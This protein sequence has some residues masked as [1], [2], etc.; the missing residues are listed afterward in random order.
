MADSKE[1][2]LLKTQLLAIKIGTTLPPRHHLIDKGPP[3]SS[4]FVFL[5][6]GCKVEASPMLAKRVGM[7]PIPIRAEAWFSVVF[8]N[9]ALKGNF[10]KPCFVAHFVKAY[11][12]RRYDS[13]TEKPENF[14]C[15]PSV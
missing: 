15:D 7:E 3:L 10:L 5:L 9:R 13:S 1:Q 4:L 11:I 8:S 12:Q 2:E 14:P 6:F